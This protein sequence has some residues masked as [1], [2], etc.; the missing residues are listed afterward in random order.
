MKIQDLNNPDL[1]ILREHEVKGVPEYRF[2]KRPI[3]YQIP[4][5]IGLRLRRERSQECNI[6]VHLREPYWFL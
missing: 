4:M 2:L 6:L 5:E 1:E 3:T